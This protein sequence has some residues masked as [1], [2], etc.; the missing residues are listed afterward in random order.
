MQSCTLDF[1]KEKPKCMLDFVEEKHKCTLGFRFCGRKKHKCMLDFVEEKCKCM[2]DFARTPPPP[3]PPPP[4]HTHNCT[5]D[6]A[7]EKQ[8][9]V[10]FCRGK[11]QTL[12]IHKWLPFEEEGCNHVIHPSVLEGWWG[13]VGWGMVL[14]MFLIT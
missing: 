10:R 6:F 12:Y 3:P 13:G 5:L 11:I 9:Y 7:E 4:T 8:T 14:P 2:S 1:V